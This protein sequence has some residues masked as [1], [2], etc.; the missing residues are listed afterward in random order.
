MNQEKR[1]EE[2]TETFR[3]IGA[4]EPHSWARSEVTE[5]IPQLCRFLF[6]RQAWRLLVTEEDDSWIDNAIKQSERSPGAPCSGIGPALK[7]LI[8]KGIDRQDL[9]DVVRVMQY[10]VLFG[11]CYLLEDPGDIEP[12]VADVCWGLLELDEDGRTGRPICG[13]HES[14]LSTDP[15]GR[16]MRPRPEL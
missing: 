14:V 5:D 3:R 4:A 2:L 15:T 8:A 13:L 1:V 6:L 16:E 11:L 7:H 12:E 10:E 9:T